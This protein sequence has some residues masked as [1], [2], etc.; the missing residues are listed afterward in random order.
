MKGS[1]IL[2]A[3][4]DADDRLLLQTA[5]QEIGYQGRLEFVA[6]GEELLD[7]LKNNLS[8]PIQP[9]VIILDLNMPKKGGKEVLSEI[10][11]ELGYKKVPIIVFSTTKNESEVQKCYELGADNYFVKPVNYSS[12]IKFVT[13]IHNLWISA[14]NIT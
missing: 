7:F 1:Y 12:L 2:I 6:N 5:F 9:G 8:Q 13:D 4:D 3:E 10:R 11:G 14:E